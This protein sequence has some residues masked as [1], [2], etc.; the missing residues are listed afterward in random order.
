MV[1]SMLNGLCQVAILPVL[2]PPTAVQ[3]MK[4]FLDSIKNAK[5]ELFEYKGQGHG[6][7]N[8]DDK[9]I[10]DKMKSMFTLVHPVCL[11]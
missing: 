6:F 8:S 3:T 5:T 7:M 11:L 4:E 1:L 2:I 9:D 10:Q